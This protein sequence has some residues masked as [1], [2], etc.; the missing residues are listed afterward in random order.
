M[1]GLTIM[2][3]CVLLSL[4]RQI[5]TLEV[6]LWRDLGGS[7]VRA[8]T[9]WMRSGS[10][11][12]LWWLGSGALE[13]VVLMSVGATRLCVCLC[14]P[15]ALVCSGPLRCVF[16]AWT[17]HLVSVVNVLCVCVF[18]NDP[19]DESSE[20]PCSGHLSGTFVIFDSCCRV[21]PTFKN[22]LSS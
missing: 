16:V 22:S 9:V 5:S 13:W 17:R 2:C 1:S 11:I 20:A 21:S 18:W 15:H 3:V 12:W 14:V 19:S 7:S 4:R 6:V 8:E 10:S